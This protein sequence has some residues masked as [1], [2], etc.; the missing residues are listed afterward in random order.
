MKP[1]DKAWK[2]EA[3]KEVFRI[4]LEP[5]IQIL[6]LINPAICVAAQAIFPLQPRKNVFFATEQVNTILQRFHSC[7]IIFAYAID[8]VGNFVRCVEKNVTIILD[9]R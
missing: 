4:Q 7:E 3:Q 9:F 8:G 5:T 6:K 2:Q 1:P